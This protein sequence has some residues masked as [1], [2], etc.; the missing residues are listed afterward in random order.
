MV[1][2]AKRK[3][4]FEQALQEHEALHEKLSRLKDQLDRRQLS[5]NEI[6][7]LLC[8]LRSFFLYHFQK[9]ERNQLFEH[10]VERA[11]HLSRL[12]DRL[13]QEHIEL[14]EQ[15]DYLVCF[16]RRGTGQPLCWHMLGVKLADFA[17][18]LHQHES[19][20]NGLL[21]RAYTDDLGTKD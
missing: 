1:M 15:I 21:Q 20:E 5:L 8:N 3:S 17:K 14:L 11:P 19:Q 18:N 13:K 6:D 2:H 10:A 7:K 16:A 9:E 12:A 4:A